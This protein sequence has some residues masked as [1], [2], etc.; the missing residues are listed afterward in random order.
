MLPV[1]MTADDRESFSVQLR[2]AEVFLVVQGAAGSKGVV[3]GRH[4]LASLQSDSSSH[5]DWLGKQRPASF[6]LLGDAAL[7]ATA[8]KF[9]LAAGC[10]AGKNVPFTSPKTDLHFIPAE[11]RIR[12]QKSAPTVSEQSRKTRVL[13]VDDSETIR[14]LL[15]Q[16]FS[17]D[18]LIECV[19]TVANP[20]N[21][22]AAIEKL[23]P[24]VITLD[25]HMPQMDGVTLLK[26][27]LADKLLPVVMISALSREEGGAVLD[28][29]EAGAVDYIQ[30]P[31]MKELAV[32]GPAICEK[33]RNARQARV[34]LPRRALVRA[35]LSAESGE[36]DPGY[37]LLLGSST[38]GTEAL[39]HVLTGLPEA[40]P[41]I[42]IV[43]H[44]PP[45]FSKAF[46][47][48]M[49]QL[50]PF[51]VKE[52]KDGDE[53]R[54]GRVIIA[55]GG[56]QMKVVQA[57]TGLKIL[58]EDTEPVNRHKPSV[59][60]LFN[61]AVALNRKQL[62]AGILTGMGADGARGLLALRGKGA[63]TFA[64]DEATS[65]VYGM[66]R[67]AARM[68]AAEKIVPL[69]EVAALLQSLSLVRKRAA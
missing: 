56:L 64:Q 17:A 6:R 21:A 37:L 36:M 12:V 16:V 19:G 8:E 50:C 31:S 47:E 48:R 69:E 27:I 20:L 62:V 34:A 3:L 46:A 40:I 68:G 63:R 13:V 39:K 51:E 35:P 7:F 58:V 28:A 55:P 10:V 61:S 44:I 41:P 25:I 5:Q 42:L 54:P 67:E 2:T 33:I 1:W 11:N 4:E 9:L 29:L 18:P 14:K 65:V 45:V 15:A 49:N 57:P 24:D 60:V 30:K 38:G 43:Q 22:M 66:P 26:K 32:S 53:V 23:Q 52:G 59:D